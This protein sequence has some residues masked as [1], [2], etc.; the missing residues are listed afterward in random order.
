MQKI[1][2]ISHTPPFPLASSKASHPFSPTSISSLSCHLAS[3]A[4]PLWGHNMSTSLSPAIRIVYR[5]PVVRQRSGRG[6]KGWAEAGKIKVSWPSLFFGSV[7]LVKS[8]YPSTLSTLLSPRAQNNNNGNFQI[9]RIFSTLELVANPT[10]KT[11]HND[12]C[13]FQWFSICFL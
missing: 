9:F 6:S 12:N 2:E 3:V 10:Q 13:H 1:D 8:T 5:K 7:F 11:Y 4:S